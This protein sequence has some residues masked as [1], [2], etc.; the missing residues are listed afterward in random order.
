MWFSPLTLHM[1]KQSLKK[2]NDLS[3]A[4]KQVAKGWNWSPDP[5]LR[6]LHLAASPKNN[7]V[8]PICPLKPLGAPPLLMQFARWKRPPVASALTWSRRV[9]SW[10]SGGQLLGWLYQDVPEDEPALPLHGLPSWDCVTSLDGFEVS[11]K[12]QG[13]RVNTT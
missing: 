12:Y 2:R 3:K 4:S 9:S 6:L 10:P 7:A 8:L 13:E 11:T 1:R 5:C